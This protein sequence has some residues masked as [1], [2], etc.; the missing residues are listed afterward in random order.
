MTRS[1]QFPKRISRRGF[2]I[3]GAGL[4][5]A[6]AGAYTVGGWID[7]ETYQPPSINWTTPSDLSRPRAPEQPIAILIDPESADSFGLYL[8]EIL[9][10]E[11]LNAFQFEDLGLI[12][13]G[14]VAKFPIILLP[15]A[16]LSQTQ[17]TL[18]AGYV[19]QGGAL[20]AMQPDPAI[21]SI[22][23]VRPAD[24]TTI[25]GYMVAHDDEDV[26]RGLAAASVPLQIHA[27]AAYYE[28]D[29]AFTIAELY[30]D[31]VTATGFPAVTRFERGL[32]RAAM[33]AY[34]LARNIALTRQGNPAAANQDRDGAAGIRANDL[35]VDWL[36][37][38]NIQSPQ[39]DIQ[40]RLLI[41]LIATMLRDRIP[42]PRL[43]YFP[44]QARSLVI[45]AGDAHGAPVTFI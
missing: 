20:I 38:D 33:F 43:W 22:F 30:R 14:Y 1:G 37:L 26:V 29:G 13:A 18:L 19:D 3:G 17:A 28:L 34:D 16:R 6:T 36:D 8:G 11:G 31:R 24:G 25:E 7:E 27:E 40:A 21:A 35:F 32:G 44:G 42:L 5:A 23:G 12:D 9:R 39:A 4:I 41:N 45:V 10:T 2:L 15:P